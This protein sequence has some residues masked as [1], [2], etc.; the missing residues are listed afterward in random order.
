MTVED[1]NNKQ[2]IYFKFAIKI[3]LDFLVTISV[4]VVALVILGQE[5]GEKFNNKILFIVMGFL[6]AALISGLIIRKKAYNY[7][8]QFEK[9]K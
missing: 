5:L 6:S 9:L 7:G 3:L 8:K 1:Q 2:S 4:P